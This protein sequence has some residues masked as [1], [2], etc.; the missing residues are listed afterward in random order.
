MGPATAIEH[1]MAA[2]EVVILDGA[3][4]TELQRRG[5]PM[6]AEAWSAAAL[7]TH[8]DEVRAVHADYIRAGSDVILTNTFGTNRA[9]LERGGLAE[10]RRELNLTAVDLAKQARAEAAEG[11]A[12]AIGGSVDIW[13]LPTD[14]G[15]TRADVEE[16]SSLLA[17]GGVDL[18]ALEM[19]IAV[20]ETALAIEAAGATGLPVW[21]GLSVK[22]SDDGEIV[23]LRHGEP[24]GAAIE[25]LAPLGA[26]VF[27]V[28]HSLPDVTGP[29]LR[30]LRAGS[31]GPIGAYAHMGAFTMPDWRWVN[32]LEPNAYADHVAEWIGL[33]ARA[34][35]GCCGLGPEYISVLS[36]RFGEGGQR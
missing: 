30:I 7:L 6:H 24:L 4:G 20:D 35:G 29:A 12:I 19:M 33:G 17:E 11:R 34:V 16:Q 27:T 28:M 14:R 25:A 18:I 8:P 21:V 31:P 9:L 3:T 1:R 22:R 13:H 36:E 26:S 32:M 2:A 5:V 10:R 23:L 15:A